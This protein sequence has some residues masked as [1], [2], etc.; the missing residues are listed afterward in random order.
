MNPLGLE[1]LE[2]YMKNDAETR[3]DSARA[4][5]LVFGTVLT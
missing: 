2:Q 3:I 5:K 4:K 1:L